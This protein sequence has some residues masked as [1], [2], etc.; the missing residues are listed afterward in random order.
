MTEIFND[1]SKKL[2]VGGHKKVFHREIVM[3]IADTNYS[4]VHLSNGK[5]ICTSTNIGKIASRL[6]DFQNFKRVHRSYLIN[7]D[8]LQAI[9]GNIII[10]KNGLTCLVSRRRREG[11]E[12][13]TYSL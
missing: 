3:I 6:T 13:F 10:L 4:Q 1:L 2:H 9:N 5:I 12:R 11:L 8:Y 7:T